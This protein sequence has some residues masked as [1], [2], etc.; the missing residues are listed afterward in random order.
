M[1]NSPDEQELPPD[2]STADIGI[3]CSHRSELAAFLKRVD[4]Q[5]KYMDRGMIFRGG[6]L[7]ETI[8]VAVVEAGS[9][10][11]SHRQAAV[12]LINE[13]H[14]A[15]VFSVGFSSAL[16]DDLRAGDLSLA[17]EI[18]DTHGNTL[19]VKCPIPESG[20]IRIRKHV[21]ADQHPRLPEDKRQLASS[22]QAAAVD[23]TSL[24]VA[25]VCHE[26]DTRF[27]SVRAII[28]TLAEEIPDQSWEAI[29]APK[30][31]KPVEAVTDLFGRFRQS[32]EVKHWHRQT[33]QA[34]ANLD[35]FLISV[36]RQLGE[37]LQRNR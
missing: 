18:C 37:K 12:T 27:L 11:A 30:A 5:R 22:H 17:N 36:T 31:R 29:F 25:Q 15:W 19:P 23:T 32:A 20:R 34:S 2:R 8:R 10:F 4:R 24:A 1:T 3:I 13:H 7:D 9:G 28:D 6:F 21:V 33:Q 14:P 16:T 26:T 35:R